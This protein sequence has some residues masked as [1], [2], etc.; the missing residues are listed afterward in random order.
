MSK[1]IIE[2][3]V[4]DSF[5][6]L[7]HQITFYHIIIKRVEKLGMFNFVILCLVLKV[8]FNFEY[9]FCVLITSGFPHYCLIPLLVYICNDLRKVFTSK[10]LVKVALKVS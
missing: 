2:T 6:N 5:N 7:E 8:C 10:V 3:H 4:W 1:L 9:P